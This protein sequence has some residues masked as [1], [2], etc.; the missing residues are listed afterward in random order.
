MTGQHSA[1]A[2]SNPA[3]AAST[4]TH[5]TRRFIQGATS[6]GAFGNSPSISGS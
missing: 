3:T 1:I 5:V 6:N 4:A 2:A